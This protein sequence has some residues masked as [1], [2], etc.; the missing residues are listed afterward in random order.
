[1]PAVQ[2][3]VRQQITTVQTVQ[4]QFLVQSHLLGEAEVVQ[5][6][7]VHMVQVK[8]ADQVAVVRK[9]VAQK[10]VVQVTHHQ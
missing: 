7:T 8:M 10:Q 4:I 3:K 6:Q 5:T 9:V 2:V 1:V